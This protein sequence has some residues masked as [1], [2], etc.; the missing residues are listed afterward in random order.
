MLLAAAGCVSAPGQS[1]ASL[2]AGEEYTDG[3][4]INR[5]IGFRITLPG[6]WLMYESEAKMPADASQYARVLRASGAEM[7]FV[8][9]SPG[10]DAFMRGIAEPANLEPADYF[11]RIELAN[12]RELLTSRHDLIQM[13]GEPGVRWVYDSQAGQIRLT[14]LEYQFRR[15]RSNVRVSFWTHSDRFASQEKEFEAVM[16]SYSAGD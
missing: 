8:A 1:S 3:Q 10:R 6:S 11:Q 14:F 13:G 2:P 7:I 15:G 12:R 4:Y 5:D 16:K 9:Q